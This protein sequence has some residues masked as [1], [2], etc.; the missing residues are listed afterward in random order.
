M[1]E[2]RR[3]QPPPM[4]SEPPSSKVRLDEKVVRKALQVNPALRAG[5]TTGQVKRDLEAGQAVR[6]EPSAAP[7]ASGSS[8]SEL[9]DTLGFFIR[10]KSEALASRLGEI[11]ERKKALDAEEAAAKK[12]L[13]DQLAS[14]VALLD[15]ATVAMHGVGALSKHKDFLAKLDVTPAS[16]L[17]AARKG[18]KS[19]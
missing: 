1:S 16:L 9:D 12:E 4:D 13:R 15:E 5:R 6:T 11:A 10:G 18:R 14:F 17:E 19:K 7:V 8:K 3:W 2:R